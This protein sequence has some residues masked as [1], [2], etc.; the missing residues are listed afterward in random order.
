MTSQPLYCLYYFCL[1]CA[2]TMVSCAYTMLTFHLYYGIFFLIYTYISH[3]T[4]TFYQKG[5]S[6]IGI[7]QNTSKSLPNHHRHISPTP[8]PP[9][10]C[11]H[12]HRRNNT[13]H[14]QSKNTTVR[15]I[16]PTPTHPRHLP[17]LAPTQQH[18]SPPV[19]KHNG[20]LSENQ[21]DKNKN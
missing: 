15:H 16:S 20:E 7:H 9:D 6:H 13:H 3:T 5:F 8:T 4:Y 19:E 1:L 11:L 14:H 17:T 12:L 18:T 2:Y 10:T 21:E